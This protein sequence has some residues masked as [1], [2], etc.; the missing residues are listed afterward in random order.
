MND[1]S[2]GVQDFSVQ[3][4]NAQRRGDGL[5]ARHHCQPARREPRTRRDQPNRGIPEVIWLLEGGRVVVG[6][7]READ[8]ER[9]GYRD[10]QS[11]R[12]AGNMHSVASTARTI[13]QVAYKRAKYT[14]G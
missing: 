4:D 8:D 6:R 5:G 13:W 1:A 3:S 12:G 11:P 7:E 10:E 14:G 2:G 9:H